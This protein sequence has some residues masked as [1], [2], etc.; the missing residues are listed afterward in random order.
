MG[1]G[2]AGLV[3]SLCGKYPQLVGQEI[4]VVTGWLPDQ[5]GQ[6]PSQPEHAY[7]RSR[8][9][10]QERLVVAYQKVGLG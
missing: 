3:K 10:R 4:Q 5:L 7:L 6:G 9:E 1:F 2:Q 8:E